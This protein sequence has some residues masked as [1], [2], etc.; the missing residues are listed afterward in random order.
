MRRLLGLIAV[1]LLLAGPLPAWNA[2]GHRIVA[3]VAW[4]QITPARRAELI[5]LLEQHPRF[6]EDFLEAMPPEVRWSWDPEVRGRW[7][8]SQACVWPDLARSQ[9]DYHHGPWHYV[10]HPLFLDAQDEARF[11]ARGGVEANLATERAP[12]DDREAWNAHQALDWSLEVLGDESAKASDRALALCWYLH[13]ASDLHQP[14]HT[15]ALFT[16]GVFPYGDRGGNLVLIEG[17]GNLHGLWDGLLGYDASLSSVEHQVQEYLGD[18]ALVAAA[19]VAAAT[20]DHRVWATEGRDAARRHA[21]DATILDAVRL[22]ERS[23]AERPAV[24]SLPATYL[25]NGAVVARRRAATAAFRI[26]GEL[27]QV[28]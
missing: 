24:V 15:T 20:T 11:E 10:N 7:L 19:R 27:A 2:A 9:P 4:S 3:L 21:Y 22:A 12:D 28:P 13:V 8:I 26:A 16:S 18:A 6:E 17:R 14:C 25:A 5:E 23:G 1:L